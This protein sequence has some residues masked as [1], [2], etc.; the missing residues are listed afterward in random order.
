MRQKLPKP[1]C[2]RPSQSFYDD[3]SYTSPEIC[4]RIRWHLSIAI[5]HNRFNKPPVVRTKASLYQTINCGCRS[6]RGQHWTPLANMPV[7]LD[8]RPFCDLARF[9]QQ[10]QRCQT[11]IDTDMS[12]ETV[13]TDVST[14]SQSAFTHLFRSSVSGTIE[15][16]FE[17]GLVL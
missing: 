10:W 13:R 17:T 6:F 16:K 3:S 2:N 8:L 5:Q 12:F 9:G 14:K 4:F 15:R 1:E 7:S 11:R